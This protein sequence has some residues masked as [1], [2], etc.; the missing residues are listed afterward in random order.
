MDANQFN[1]QADE[2]LSHISMD[3]IEVDYHFNG[4][5][6]RGE[7]KEK[8]YH[9][10]PELAQEIKRHGQLQPIIVTQIGS[11][12]KKPFAL[13][14]GFRRFEALRQLGKKEAYVRV[15][16]PKAEK[17]EKR[18]AELLLINAIE[19]LSREQ[20][21]TYEQAA[22]MTRLAE[23]GL[24]PPAIS[25]YLTA[26]ITGENKS[27]FSE[28][29]VSNLISCFTKLHPQLLSKWRENKIPL[30]VLNK[31]KLIQPADEQLDTQEIRPYLTSSSTASDT[32]AAST[33]DGQDGQP[34]ADPPT[35]RPTVK[36][37]ASVADTVKVFRKEGKIDKEVAGAVIKVLE[38][39]MGE[40]ASLRI[41]KVNLL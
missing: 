15:Y 28:T 33:G 1:E 32:P 4:R 7:G 35:R 39:V 38:F 10:I 36:R 23:G 41:A 17:E 21:T 26:A 37:L 6:L 30:R 27:G 18:H 29:H 16:S 14:A 3:Q 13:I 12:I 20:L 5:M 22:Q 8:Q 34:P 11:G 24:K 31:V 19:N 25:R 40:S 2:K 9:G